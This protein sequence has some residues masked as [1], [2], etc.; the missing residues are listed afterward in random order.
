MLLIELFKSDDKT[1]GVKFGGVVRIF[2][3]WFSVAA[4][5]YFVLAR[6]VGGSCSDVA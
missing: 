2:A 1:F 6:H 5:V 3:I 4:L